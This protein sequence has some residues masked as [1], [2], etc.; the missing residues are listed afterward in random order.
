MLHDRGRRGS[1]VQSIIPYTC[2][3]T[4]KRTQARRGA[5]AVRVRPRAL[6]SANSHVCA[7]LAT[8][9][10]RKAGGDATK[11]LLLIAQRDNSRLMSLRDAARELHDQV[12]E[13]RVRALH[14]VHGAD[15][16]YD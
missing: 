15:D 3:C 16:H 13:V 14:V 6:R 11:S 9:A 7:V 5:G 4:S 1:T 2:I 8:T 10:C 12:A